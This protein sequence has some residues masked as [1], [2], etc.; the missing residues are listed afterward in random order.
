MAIALRP[1]II[2][3]VV[4]CWQCYWHQERPVKILP[5]W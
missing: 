3:S 5:W 1:I 4:P 2:T